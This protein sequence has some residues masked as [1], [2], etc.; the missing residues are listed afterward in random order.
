MSNLAIA[1]GILFRACAATGF[2]PEVLR[3]KS[4][5][6]AVVQT[7]QAIMYVLRKRT[8]F[9]FPQIAKFV[10][11]TDHTTAIHAMESVVERA[12]RNPEYEAFVESLMTADPVKPFSAP[13]MLIEHKITPAIPV[14]SSGREWTAPE[15]PVVTVEAHHRPEVVKRPPVPRS[16][17]KRPR[18]AKKATY[19]LIDCEVGPKFMVD[20]KGRDPFENR[21]EASIIAGSRGLALSI[22][23][24]RAQA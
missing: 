11:R 8:K 1:E 15:P 5:I 13:A 24:A 22:L 20:E 6:T 18:H 12:K 10:G 3:S 19:Q 16:C 9:S 17:R 21:L 23:T 4:R 7:R 14:A 2:Y